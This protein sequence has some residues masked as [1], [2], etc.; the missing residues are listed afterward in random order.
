MRFNEE[1]KAWEEKLIEWVKENGKE[2]LESGET[3]VEIF[4]EYYY[5]KDSVHDFCDKYLNGNSFTIT[6]VCNMKLDYRKMQNG[7]HRVDRKMEA[8]HGDLLMEYYRYKRTLNEI[9]KSFFNFCT[10]NPIKVTDDMAYREPIQ[11]EIVFEQ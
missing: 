3:T 6:D 10:P 5:L 2:F 4:N 9:M 7:K 8:D 11:L 1:E